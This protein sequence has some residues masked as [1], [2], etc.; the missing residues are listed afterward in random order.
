MTGQ[1]PQQDDQQGRQ[2]GREPWREAISFAQRAHTGQTRRDGQTPYAS[3]VVRVMMTV[4]D[5]FGCEDGVALAAAAL[6]DTI[7]DTPTDYDDLAGAFGAPVA[8][9]VAALTKNMLLPETPREADYDTRLRAADWRGRLIKLADVLDN[10][11]DSGKPRADNKPRATGKLRHKVERAIA[12]A[13]PD[14][15]DHPETAR[16]IGLVSALLDP[17]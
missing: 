8:D 11:A 17:A 1:H 16:A 5:T 10:A 7:E 12:L 4:R 13:Q 3:H 9:I 6:H 2:L 15:A 14:A